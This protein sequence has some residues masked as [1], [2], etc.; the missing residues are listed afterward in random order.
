MEIKRTVELFVE[1]NRR[2]VIRQS[3]QTK[4][5]FCP[6]CNEP[7][8]AAEQAALLYGIGRREV[9]RQVENEN[10]HFAEIETGAVMICISSLATACDDKNKKESFGESFG[11]ITDSAAKDR[12]EEK[13]EF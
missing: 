9:Y 2:F 8:L 1:T 5:F 11:Q 4:P 3:D 13:S 6:Q 7:M 12:A 10:I